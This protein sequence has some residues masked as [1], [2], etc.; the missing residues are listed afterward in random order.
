MD[1]PARPGL[2]PMGPEDAFCSCPECGLLANHELKRGLLSHVEAVHPDGRD[3]I[4]HCP[5]NLK[6]RFPGTLRTC[7]FC[8]Y[9]WPTD[10]SLSGPGEIYQ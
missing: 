3:V 2:L 4:E 6:P 5:E 1:E 8:G 10:L 9:Y 7:I